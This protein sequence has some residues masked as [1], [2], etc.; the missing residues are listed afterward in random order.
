MTSKYMARHRA[1]K[2]VPVMQGRVTLQLIANRLDV[3][4][5]TVSLALR[6]SPLVAE[7]TK[8]RVQKIARE[9]GYSYNRSA[10]SLRTARTNMIGVGFHDITN[11]YFAELLAAIEETTASEGLSILLGTYAENL[12]RQERVLTTFREYRPDGIILC[13]A[14]GTSLGVYQQVMAAG[15]PLVQVS[16]EI[17]GAELDFVGADD[18]RGTELALVHL[19]GL[20]H[21]RIALIGGTDSISTGRRRRKSYRLVMASLGLPVDEA[22]MIEGFGTRDTGFRAMHRLL[23]MQHPPSAAICF[24]DLA[25][26]GAML[27]LRHREREAGRDFAVVGCDDVSEAAQWFPALTT[28]HN[29]QGEM[30]AMA[31]RMMMERIADPFRNPQR[32]II[33]PTLVVRAS[34]MPLGG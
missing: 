32:V 1:E 26:F 8:H 28:I 31:A 3:S 12:E 10:A 2:P 23:D 33:A 11:P 29:H 16:R 6:N 18:A 20:G 7:T 27:A 4:T 14:G 5:A 22:L 25:A 13:P 34:T 30:G 9:M 15:I 24:N 17:E 19:H 21:R